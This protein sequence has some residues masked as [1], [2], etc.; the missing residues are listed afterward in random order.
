MG[1]SYPK[2]TKKWTEEEALQW[3]PCSEWH[4]QRCFKG[5]QL[6]AVVF[7]VPLLG[8]DHAQKANTRILLKDYCGFFRHAN[9]REVC[10]WFPHFPEYSIHVLEDETE[11]ISGSFS[12]KTKQ[13]KSLKRDPVRV[14]I[15]LNRETSWKTYLKCVKYIRAYYCRF[16]IH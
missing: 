15:N 10:I 9:K 11:D 16:E 14:K 3:G 8:N 5:S 7:N 4:F 2:D 13:N 12:I 1:A 6:G